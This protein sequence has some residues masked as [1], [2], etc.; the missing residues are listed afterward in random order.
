MRCLHES[1]R[2]KINI[3]KKE[4][5]GPVHGSDEYFLHFVFMQ[6]YTSRN[7][8][9]ASNN[10][11][12]IQSHPVTQ[13]VEHHGLAFHLGAQAQVAGSVLVGMCEGNNWSMFL[14]S[15]PFISLKKKINNKIKNIHII[16]L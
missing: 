11:T 12:K 1:K 15:S 3:S 8:E 4:F 10:T 14:S 2:V 16:L 6:V 9:A 5:A 13:L 7:S